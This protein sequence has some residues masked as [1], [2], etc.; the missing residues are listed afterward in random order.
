MRRR[1]GSKTIQYCCSPGGAA[2]D[3]LE[4]PTIDFLILADRAEVINGKLYMMGG[5][6]D[7]LN[8]LDVSQPVGFALAIGVLIP[9]SALYRDHRL[10]IALEDEDGVQL[11]ELRAAMNIGAPAE[12][13]I[14]QSFRAMFALNV[15]WKLPGPGTYRVVAGVDDGDEKRVALHVAL[16]QPP[17]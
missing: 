2:T 15:G 3:A 10:R 4:Q 6:W 1:A 17:R 5:G 7:R 11:T 13:T 14:G 12:V 8:L 16:A 9:W